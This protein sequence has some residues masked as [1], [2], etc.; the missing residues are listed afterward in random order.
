MACW[1]VAIQQDGMVLKRD[2]SAEIQLKEV[3]S[4]K[5]ITLYLGENAQPLPENGVLY[6]KNILDFPSVFSA[7]DKLLSHIDTAR[8]GKMVSSI[9]ELLLATNR[10]ATQMDAS[11]LSRSLRQTDT[12]TRELSHNLPALLAQTEQLLRHADVALSSTERM[13]SRTD[14]RI[15]QFSTEADRRLPRA[16]SLLTQT[17]N[18]LIQASSTLLQVQAV[19]HSLPDSAVLH[20]SIQNLNQTLDYLREK[21]LNVHV[22]LRK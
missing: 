7:A 8:L 14:A 2:A 17:E 10:L 18:A 19:L 16:D 5:Q 4:G 9:E 11:T 1:W 21:K 12:L 6:G 13:L 15:Q 22:S 20:H 3:L